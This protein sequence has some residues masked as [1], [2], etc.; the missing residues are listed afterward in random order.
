[1]KLKHNFWQ[2]SLYIAYD[3]FPLLHRYPSG[4]LCVI[5][6]NPRLACH[7]KVGLQQWNIIFIYTER[8]KQHLPCLEFMFSLKI[9]HIF[10]F[11]DAVIIR[12][13]E[14]G[15]HKSVVTLLSHFKYRAP[16]RIER[17]SLFKQEKINATLKAVDTIGNYSK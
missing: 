5:H 3:P 2:F 13:S 1:M 10:S 6:T 14:E 8:K 16:L 4:T 12:K 15:L 11:R 7:I 17:S 9:N